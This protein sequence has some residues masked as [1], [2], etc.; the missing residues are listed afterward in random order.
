MCP[1]T[2]LSQIIGMG[3]FKVKFL[4]NH[5]KGPILHAFL[6]KIVNDDKKVSPHALRIGGRTWYLSMDLEKQFVDY[7]GTWA[8]PEASARYY[9]ANPA[10][11]MKR[12]QRFYHG[13][14]KNEAL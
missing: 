9:R 2:A 13:L 11:V 5:G 10:A 6:N 7:L 14:T 12:L 4:R 8:S 3:L 1:A